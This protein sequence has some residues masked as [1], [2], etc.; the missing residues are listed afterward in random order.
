[1]QSPL[2]QASSFTG[3]F[4]LLGVPVSVTV[5]V[6]VSVTV[7]VAVSVTVDVATDELLSLSSLCIQ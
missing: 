4:G 2:G 3:G 1:M 7:D 5:D 6:A